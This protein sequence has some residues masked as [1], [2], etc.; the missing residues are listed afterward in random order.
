MAVSSSTWIE[1]KPSLGHIHERSKGV[2][3][4]REP[5]IFLLPTNLRHF[6]RSHHLRFLF[7]K[8]LFSFLLSLYQWRVVIVLFH[9]RRCQ[10]GMEPARNLLGMYFS[11]LLQSSKIKSVVLIVDNATTS[12]RRHVPVATEVTVTIGHH[13]STRPS[14]SQSTSAAFGNCHFFHQVI[15]PPASQIMNMSP[16]GR[17]LVLETRTEWLESD[18]ADEIKSLS[19]DSTNESESLK[20]TML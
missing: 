8:I 18:K 6:N 14:G 16:L 12:S 13:P 5:N 20:K 7:T 11:E 17:G 3:G 2:R 10:R 4:R 9:S 15:V 19:E 1:E